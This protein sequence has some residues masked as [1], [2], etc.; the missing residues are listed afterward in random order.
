[1]SI[2]SM[3]IKSTLQALFGVLLMASAACADVQLPSIIGEH[4]VL[5]REHPVAIWGWDTPG[6]KVRVSFRGRDETVEASTGEGKWLVRMPSGAAGGPFPLQIKGTSTVELKDV[7]VG[8]VWVA[9]GQ[10]NMWW[11]LRNS[12]NAQ[13]EI[14][15]ATDRAIRV[16][17]A[18]T[19]PREAGWPADKTQRT[20]Q[21]QWLVNTP[22]N[23]GEFPATAYSCALELHKRLKVP[24]GIVH[25]AVPGAAIEEFLSEAYVRRALPQ[26][27]ELLEYKR[28]YYEQDKKT[29]QEAHAAWQTQ[30]SEAEKRGDKAPDEPKEP[31][32]PNDVRLGGAFYNGMIVPA[33]PFTTRGFLWWQ[34]E[35]NADRAAQYK[36]LFPALIAEWRRLWSNDNLPFLYVELANFGFK[37][38]EPIHDDAWPA[39]RDAQ[40]SALQLPYVY[41]ISVIDILDEEG[42]VW[43]IHPLNKQLAGQR[44]ALTALANVY[45]QKDIHWSGP[46]FKSAMIDYGFA[47]LTFDHAMGGL[48]TRDGKPLTG[49]AIAGPD[50]QWHPADVMQI[51]T[52][53]TNQIVLYSHKVLAPV[54]VRY[55]WAL[56]PTGNLSNKAGLPAPPFRTD[57]WNLQP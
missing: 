53:Q 33:A 48:T 4:M 28:R 19:G 57:H 24:V 36:V 29:W 8:E 11:Q 50:R 43:N 52:N 2:K 54:A 25:L 38:T 39:L 32:N 3:S 41:R 51:R 16:Y 40:A 31:Q 42:P 26:Q 1:M 47:T 20:I 45:G 10:S 49:F 30:K 27:A 5:Q 56:N 18:N 44:L 22:E 37:Q 15:A 7:M 13:Q 55:G 34:G 12:K 21:T 17:D 14:A 9:G 46:T 6:T 35:S 23:A